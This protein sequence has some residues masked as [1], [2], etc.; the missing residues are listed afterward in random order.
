MVLV[1]MMILVA[2][3]SVGCSNRTFRDKINYIEYSFQYHHKD[4][5]NPVNPLIKTYA[6]NIEDGLHTN[7]HIKIKA[8]EINSTSNS[9][10]QFIEDFIASLNTNTYI[11]NF[12]TQNITIG[13]IAGLNVQG[14]KYF[15]NGYTSVPVPYEGIF[16]VFEYKKILF[17]ADFLYPSIDEEI[18]GV[19]ILF[20]RTF[21]IEDNSPEK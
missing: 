13:Q 5:V 11:K 2:T 8:T 15:Y 4:K 6:D 17:Q 18:N 21:K 14:V 3:F 7:S 12:N 9:H 20:Q 16:I 1:L 10:T 19:F